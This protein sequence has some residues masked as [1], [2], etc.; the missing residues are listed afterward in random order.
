MMRVARGQPCQAKNFI[1]ALRQ[2][3]E[4]VA[5]GLLESNDAGSIIASSDLTD[6][7]VETSKDRSLPRRAQSLCRFLLELLHKELLKPAGG[8]LEGLLTVP[9]RQLTQVVTKVKAERTNEGRQML[10]DLQYPFLKTAAEAAAIKGK[11]DA[12]PEPPAAPPADRPSFAGILEATLRRKDEPMRAW[13]DDSLQY[14]IIQQQRCPTALPEVLTVATGLHNR[15]N[16]TWWAPV[17][18]ADG[19][20]RPWLP[21]RIRIDADP[22]T[23]DVRVCEGAEAE[24]EGS[25]PPMPLHATYRL[26][27]IIAHVSEVEDFEIEAKGPA[28]V[29]AREGHLVA[30]VNVG[31]PYV[32]LSTHTALATPMTMPGVSPLPLGRALSRT[33]AEAAEA[34]ATAA[35]LVYRVDMA[36]SLGDPHPP[37]TPPPSKRPSGPLDAGAFGT[38]VITPMSVSRGTAGATPSF[39]GERASHMWV[40]LNDFHVQ[41]STWQEVTDPFGGQQVP[42]LLF[43]R[44]TDGSA[45]ANDLPVRGAEVLTAK[46]FAQIARA[47][48]LQ[49]VEGTPA[50]LTL[51]AKRFTP[52]DM[53]TEAPRPGMLLGI[54]AEFVAFSTAEKTVENGVEI[55]TRPARLGLARVSVVRGEGPRG[56]TCCLDDHV[57]AV[58]PV[59][60]YLTRFSGVQEGDL[61]AQRSKHY[62]TNLKASYLKLR[63]LLDQGCVFVGHGL[64][65]DF[66]M[67]NLLVPAE[68][69]VS[70]RRRKR[71]TFL[72]FR[73]LDLLW[74]SHHQVIIR[75]QCEFVSLSCAD[76][77]G[78][79]LPFQAAA[80]ALPSVPRRLPAGHRDSARDARLHR[81]RLRRRQALPRVQ[82]PGR[83]GRLRGDLAG[84]VSV[85]QAAS[86]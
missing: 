69:M 26:S 34:E 55:V 39:R 1:R 24:A 2:A 41:E 42:V 27:T 16:L 70:E 83:P 14:Q 31:H 21:D 44:R 59:V 40:S 43:F 56:V 25:S 80:Q 72:F 73:P 20:Q 84:N 45:E 48:S 30:H 28:A 78:G 54:D 81:G 67:L 22:A 8:R 66:K 86:V 63:Y 62:L 5:L 4:A 10:I 64:K 7:E 9:H 19:T 15:H 79:A 52:L 12:A 36:R 38:P 47:P 61:D 32:D 68:Q 11:A 57:R 77:Y 13:F 37:V 82:G 18:G 71:R 85:R 51:G 50:A 46:E 6:I 60:D 29:R 53:S 35:E 75:L 3:R 58:E 49:E 65:K 74:P 76:R 17:T 33:A 23:Y